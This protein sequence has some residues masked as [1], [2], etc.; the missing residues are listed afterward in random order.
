MKSFDNN[1]LLILLFILELHCID[2]WMCCGGAE[3]F[4]VSVERLID[5]LKRQRRSD[6]TNHVA[7]RRT[8]RIEE[9]KKRYKNIVDLDS[10]NDTLSEFIKRLLLQ[11]KFKFFKFYENVRPPYFGMSHTHT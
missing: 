7:R 9:R 8:Q 6:S 1:V 2:F 5:E 11:E 4:D 3:S 10:A